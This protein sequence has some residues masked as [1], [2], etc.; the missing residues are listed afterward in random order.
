MKLPK[1]STIPGYHAMVGILAASLLSLP[2]SAADWKSM[3][4]LPA[5][6]YLAA[7]ESINGIIYVA[8]GQG[9]SGPTSTLQAFNPETKTWSR[10]ANLPLTL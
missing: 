10:L 3:A 7:A 4:P 5:S 8:G 6:N 9:S 1:V 2:A